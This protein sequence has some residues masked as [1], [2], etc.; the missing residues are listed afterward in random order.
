MC[1]IWWRC[2]DVCACV[3]SSICSGI[4]EDSAMSGLFEEDLQD[5]TSDTENTFV[6]SC[7]IFGVC[8]QRLD[9]LLGAQNIMP[10]WYRV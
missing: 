6:I 2:D 3:R 7:S 1:F 4:E 10:W 8:D 9:S 5:F